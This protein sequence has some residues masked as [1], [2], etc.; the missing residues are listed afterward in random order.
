MASSL[1]GPANSGRELRRRRIKVGKCIV[2]SLLLNVE[3][4]ADDV[5][6]TAVDEDDDFDRSTLFSAVTTIE[7]IIIF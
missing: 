5:L 7:L 3:P 2:D 4:A 6:D 1:P